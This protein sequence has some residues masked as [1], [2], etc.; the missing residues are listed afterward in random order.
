MVFGSWFLVNIARGS[1]VGAIFGSPANRT[2]GKT[3]LIR[4]WFGTKIVIW[5]F[6]NF[7]VP[8]FAHFHEITMNFRI[9]MTSLLSYPNTNF[10]SLTKSDEMVIFNY[11]F[12]LSVKNYTKNTRSLKKIDKN[13]KKSWKTV[14]FFWKLLLILGKTAL[15]RGIAVFSAVCK[16]H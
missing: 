2:I 16:P 8:F 1:P 6:W 14:D 13:W 10:D 5:D 9:T 11:Y 15:N 12:V 4:V 3:A 7:K